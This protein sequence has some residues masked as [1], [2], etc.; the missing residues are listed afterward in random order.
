MNRKGN[1]SLRSSGREANRPGGRRM[2]K[3]IGG[4][5]LWLLIVLIVTGCETIQTGGGRVESCGI[6]MKYCAPGP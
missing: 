5:I 3:A 2:R 1:E 4:V 6:D